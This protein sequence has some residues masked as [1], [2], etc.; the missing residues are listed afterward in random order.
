MALYLLVTA[1]L[2]E[3]ADDMNALYGQVLRRSNLNQIQALTSD[4]E[5]ALRKEILCPLS[6]AF[7]DDHEEDEAVK[8]CAGR[9]DVGNIVCKGTCSFTAF[10][11]ALCE[12]LTCE[13]GLDLCYK[14]CNGGSIRARLKVGYTIL[15]CNHGA[16]SRDCFEGANRR[17]TVLEVIEHTFDS[18][19][20]RIRYD[21]GNEEMQTFH[22]KFLN[23][24]GDTEVKHGTKWMCEDYDY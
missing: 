23:A 10:L 3:R 22:F 12:F 7:I 24:A 4:A 2:G 20:H 14:Q 16:S 11:S 8:T 15:V 18:T 1:A 6:F 9:C 5:D 19:E 17:A 13:P 21:N